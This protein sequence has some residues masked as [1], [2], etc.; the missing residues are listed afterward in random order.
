M[1][2]TFAIQMILTQAPFKKQ[3]V[4][5]GVR[6][7][8]LEIKLLELGFGLQTKFK[9]LRRAPFDG[10]IT[11]KNEKTQIILRGQDAQMIEVSFA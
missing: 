10:P 9:V 7:A 1:Q 2:C 6:E 11:L 5:D 3:L 4:L 8:T